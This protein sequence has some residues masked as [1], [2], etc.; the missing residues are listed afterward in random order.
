TA[1]D[2]EV[3]IEPPALGRGEAVVEI[4]GLPAV[5]NGLVELSGDASPLPSI[6]WP[7]LEVKLQVIPGEDSPAPEVN[8]GPGADVGE[9]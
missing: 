4:T 7:I 1:A 6:F 8:L 2:S 5:L 9:V 3:P